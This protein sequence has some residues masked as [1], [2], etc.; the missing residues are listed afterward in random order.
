MGNDRL[1]KD[2]SN[3]VSE[4]SNAEISFLWESKNAKGL[5]VKLPKGFNGI[6]ETDGTVLHSVVIQGELNYTL[7]QN[8]VTK[9]LDTGSY[10][11]ATSKAIH[12]ISNNSESEVILYIRT[13][14][15]ITIK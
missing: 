1:N 4:K 12:T 10:F 5:F 9:I 8:Q 13:N 11:G 15:N 6:I 14:G 3:W 2:K 7:P